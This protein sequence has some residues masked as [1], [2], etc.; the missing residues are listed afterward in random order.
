MIRP[1][2]TPDLA[3]ARALLQEH[4]GHQ[5]F[6]PGQWEAI[7]A[8]LAGRDVLA[9]LPTG[10]G[11]SILYQLPALMK[12][13]FVLVVSPLV[14]LMH[15]QVDAL[16]RRGIPAFALTSELDYRKIDQ[17]WTDAEFK[18][19]K[20]LYVTPER[21]ETELFQ[22]RAERLPISLLAVDEA[23]C[24]SEWG[25]DFRPAYRRIAAARSLIRDTEGQPVP[26]LAVTATA[27]PDVRRDIVE[28][29]G[30]EDPTLIVR[31]FDRPNIVWAIYRD[32]NKAQKLAEITGAVEGSGIVYA[33]TRRGSEEWAARLRE[34]GIS[35]ESYHAGLQAERKTE[36]QRRWLDNTTRFIVAT[37]AFGMGI[38]KP[39]VRL[40][41][42]VALPPTLEAY[43]QEAGRAGRDGER[44]WAVL[45]FQESDARLPQALADEGHPDAATVQAVYAAAGSLAQVP[46]GSE[47][48]GP[49]RLDPNRLAEVAGTTPRTARAAIDVLTDVGVW[50]RIPP[51]SHRALVQVLQPAEA[52]RRYAT[53]L[54]NASLADFMRALL[55]GLPPEAFSEWRE[56]ELRPLEKQT[57]LE[58]KRVLR[59]FAFL[60][61]QGLLRFY[62]PGEG[63]Q[64]TFNGARTAKAALDSASLARSRRRAARNLDA[65]LSYARSVHCR[66]HQ[67]LS[68][69]GEKAPPRCGRC[70]VC[71]GRHR[72]HTVTPDNEPHLRSILEHIDRGDPRDT[73]L[74]GAGLA[75]YR[76]DG[77][78]D[79]L[80]HEGFLTVADPLADTLTLT[81]R[82]H[83]MLQRRRKARDE[84]S[85]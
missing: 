28:Q 29:L 20:L 45:L 67:L 38:D 1:A 2:P 62:P 41:I 81:P 9:V 60:A 58:R 30:L 4:W 77:L 39:D 24:I 21:L 82:A 15:D 64:V 26:V 69:F 63:L 27:T 32:E 34:K 35:A 47:P 56:V 53:G 16:G 22:A 61:E 55:R 18:R 3:T 79:W 25:H 74:D 83:R 40:V 36:V 54:S 57:G 17:A 23:H 66:R 14:A 65:V 71:L 13:G 84:N 7:E 85:Q 19:Y 43:Y 68:Y 11:K 80:V 5:G 59:G 6:R 48:E 46:M 78:A 31:G 12:E 49:V 50:Q 73:W 52:I 33:G 70:D 72:P 51:R 37:S 42:H 76:R 8:T 10:G 44:A 75:P